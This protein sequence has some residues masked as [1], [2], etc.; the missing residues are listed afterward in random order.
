MYVSNELMLDG[1]THCL[2][3]HPATPGC[4]HITHVI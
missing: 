3:E 1:I 4:A 2:L